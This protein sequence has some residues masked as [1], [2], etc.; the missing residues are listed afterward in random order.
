MHPKDLSILDFTYHLPAEK[1]AFHPSVERDR[2]RLLVYDKGN[3]KDDIFSNITNYLPE[4]CLLIFNDTK[5]IKAR[6][7]FQ[8][9][10]GGIIEIFCLE[11]YGAMT[12][13]HTLMN[14]RESVKWKCMIGGAGKWKGGML[15]KKGKIDH[16]Q[17]AIVNAEWTISVMLVE[18]LTDAYVAEFKWEP[19]GLS[20]AEILELAGDIP[21][22]PYIKR[23]TEA[24]DTIRY[25]TVYAKEQG[26]VAAPTAGLHFTNE[27]FE[28]LTKKNIITDFVTLHVGVGT[29][30]PVKSTTMK[31]HEMHEEWIIV[32]LSTLERLQA[33]LHN[34][35]IAVGTTSARTLESIYWMGVKTC[36]HP[37]IQQLEMGQWDVYE[38]KLAGQDISPGV[39]LAA[40]I[41]WIKQKGLEKL[42][43]TTKLMIA[44]GYRFNMINGIV[45]NFHQPQSTL[46]LLVAAAI[47][48]DWKKYYDHALQNEYRFLSY[49][50]VCLLFINE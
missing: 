45:T 11:P 50:D 13:Y 12:G 37:G 49:G 2:S 21:L 18:K 19:A 14:T 17:R 35:C 4:S 31:D 29:F 22:P 25:Q 36:I 46:L 26:S 28:S 43:T 1:I 3:I 47:G 48:K 24:E 34:P 38:E 42:F 6:I 8:K 33:N 9:P 16:R 40:L 41:K 10:T 39:A 44:P 32:H 23:M 27:V 15:E 5:V 7:R 30:K 20:F